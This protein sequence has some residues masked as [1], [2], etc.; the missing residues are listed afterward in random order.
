MKL[1]YDRKSKNPTYFVAQS[2]RHGKKTTSFNVAKIGKHSEL[3]ASGH[4]DP[5]SYAKEVVK[6]YNLELSDDKASFDINIDFTKKLSPS[7][8]IYS[9]ST[10][11]A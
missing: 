6:N 2:I 10:S 5:L 1:S 7:N 11:L 9:K 3:L 4:S 8:D